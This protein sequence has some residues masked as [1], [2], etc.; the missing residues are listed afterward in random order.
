MTRPFGDTPKRMGSRLFPRTQTFRN[1][2]Y[3]SA[4]RPRS[5]GF[6]WP[7]VPPRKSKAFCEQRCRS[8][9]AS[10]TKRKNP[11]SFSDHAPRR[12]SL[13]H[14]WPASYYRAGYYDPSTGR[15]L[16][17]DPVEFRGGGTNLY[18]YVLNSPLS[19][20]DPS[21]KLAIGA[22]IGGVVGGIS[23][24]VGARLQGGSTLDIIGA[25]LGGAATGILVGALDP[26]EGVFTVSQIALIGGGMGVLGDMIG[27]S[28][29]I[30]GRPCK[31]FDLGQAI[32]AGIGGI[33][34]GYMGAAMA[35][36]AASVGVGSLGQALMGGAVS[37][38]PATLGGPT[39]AALSGGSGCGCR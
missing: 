11:A 39:G 37:S 3:S 31:S 2:A 21:G 15:F 22:I 29:A 14:F 36:G 4:P 12:K 23:A 6:G 1:E 8:L 7:T 24:G 18:V 38:A 26:T 25:A 17:V 28:I 27:Q 10:S 33:A 9:R 5:F 35:L 20:R 13:A 32:G 19:L 16:S 34:A 30:R